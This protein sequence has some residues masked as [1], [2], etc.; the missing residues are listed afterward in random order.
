MNFYINDFTVLIFPKCQLKNVI[1][2]ND[3]STKT[4]YDIRKKIKL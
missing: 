1:E 4:V 3:D 2:N